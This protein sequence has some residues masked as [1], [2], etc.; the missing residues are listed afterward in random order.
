[1]DRLNAEITAALRDDA[2]QASMRAQGVEP[3]PSTSE[4]FESYIRSETAKWAKVIKT[5]NIKLD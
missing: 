1:V 3:A 4:A 5:A 2:I